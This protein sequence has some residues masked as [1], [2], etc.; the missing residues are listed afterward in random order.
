MNTPNTAS[1]HRRTR[2]DHARETAVSYLALGLTPPELLGG[3]SGRT[4]VASATVWKRLRDVHGTCVRRMRH[5]VRVD[6]SGRLETTLTLAGVRALDADLNDAA[7]RTDLLR[8]TCTA[9]SAC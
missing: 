6:E 3:T 2:S 9:A 7:T 1:A 5:V 4:P 8:A